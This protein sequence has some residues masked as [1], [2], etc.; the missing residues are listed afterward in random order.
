M[1]IHYSQ[2]PIFWGHIICLQLGV[3]LN[4]MLDWQLAYFSRHIKLTGQ[5]DIL[6]LENL[7]T[8]D[9]SFTSTGFG[10]VPAI[11]AY[12]LAWISNASICC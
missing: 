11:G 4:L 10:V 5:E 9:E 12:Y 2:I 3:D 7:F 1:K 6:D 8:L